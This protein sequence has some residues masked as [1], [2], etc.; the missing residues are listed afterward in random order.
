MVKE[1]SREYWS[2]IETI[3]KVKKKQVVKVNKEDWVFIIREW[4]II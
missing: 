4:D 1:D 2:F 3:T